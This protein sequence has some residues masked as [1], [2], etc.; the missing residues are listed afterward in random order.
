MRL[1]SEVIVQEF[2]HTER[3]ESDNYFFSDDNG[4]SGIA[5]VSTHHFEY[6]RL[7]MAHVAFFVDDASRR[8]VGL[9]ELARRSTGLGE[10]E[11]AWHQ[12]CWLT[13]SDCRPV[14]ALKQ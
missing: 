1:Q 8:E 12:G 11:N 2:V 3:I 10:E 6:G 7:V 5:A 9:N 14:S 13:V 4:G